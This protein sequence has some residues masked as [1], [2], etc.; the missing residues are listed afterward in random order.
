MNR[1]LAIVVSLTILFSGLSVIAFRIERGKASETIFIRADGSIDPPTAPIATIDSIT[2]TFTGNVYEEIVVERSNIII[3][4]NGYITQGGGD[5]SGFF[6]ED[7]NNV[8]LKNMDIRN[9]RVGIDLRGASYNLICNSAIT[10]NEWYG[11]R[12]FFNSEHNVIVGNTITANDNYGVWFNADNNVFSRNIVTKHK[13]GVYMEM[14]DSNI[15]TENTI[16][17]NPNGGI[18]LWFSQNNN[19]SG[20]TITYSN[21]GLYFHTSSSNNVFGNILANN[22]DGVSLWYSSGNNFYHNN[23]IDNAK[24]VFLNHS[25]ANVWDAGY[26]SGGNYWSNYTGMDTD[27]D[28]IGDTPHIIDLDNTDRYPLIAPSKVF[29][30]GIWD[31]TQCNIHIISNSTLSGFQLNKAEKTIIFYVTGEAGFGFCRVA[32][33]KVIV[34]ELW[35]NNFTVYVNGGDPL[36]V[37]NWTDSAYTYIYFTY[38]HSTHKITII[39]EFSSIAITVLFATTTLLIALAFKRKRH[40]KPHY[41]SHL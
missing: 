12:I 14:S 29:D 37:N 2:Y 34:Q 41:S 33:P 15:I 40:T 21:Y 24:Q 18:E 32:I 30:V 13:I 11:I 6:L 25:E 26:P 38:V 16:T 9:F 10:N 3:D 31:E 5:G 23:F 36:F 20:N 4:G 22:N 17:V 39:P 19:I 27:K 1:K 8:T 35:Q 28:G 7:V